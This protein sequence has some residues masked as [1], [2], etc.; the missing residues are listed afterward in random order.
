MYASLLKDIKISNLKQTD[1]VYVFRKEGVLMNW[2]YNVEG[3][4]IKFV[5]K[6]EITTIENLLEEV[7]KY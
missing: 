4:P 6:L 7:R 1:L 3:L 5:E 2:Y